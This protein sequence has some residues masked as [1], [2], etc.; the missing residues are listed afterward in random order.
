MWSPP[1]LPGCSLCG[2]WARR[3]PAGEPLA[4]H[5]R[6]G[7]FQTLSRAPSQALLPGPAFLG[8]TCMWPTQ[9]CWT[10]WTAQPGKILAS[11]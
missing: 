2:S 3:A 11:A 4:V 7:M 10:V 6:A 1:E 5:R 9:T 8:V